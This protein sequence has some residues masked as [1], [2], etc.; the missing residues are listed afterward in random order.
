MLVLFFGLFFLI[1]FCKK[2]KRILLLSRQLDEGTPSAPEGSFVDYQTSMVKH[3]KA[4]AVTAQEMV[5]IHTC[6]VSK[7]HFLSF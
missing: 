6:L 4:I 7:I 1:L 3:S 5:R 2:T